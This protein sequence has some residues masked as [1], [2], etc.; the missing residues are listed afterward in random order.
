MESG[1]LDVAFSA[2]EDVL[3]TIIEEIRRSQEDFTGRT[4][5]PA[6]VEKILAQHAPQNMA[7]L[8]ERV[9]V[10]EGSDVILLIR[11]NP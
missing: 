6:V 2:A 10:V 5:L 11:W 9:S 4:K 1:N 7:E 3:R 8:P